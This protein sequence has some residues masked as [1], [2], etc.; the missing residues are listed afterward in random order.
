MP[1]ALMMDSPSSGSKGSTR[2]L[3]S[4]W[5]PAGARLLHK[6]LPQGCAMRVPQQAAE[7]FFPPPL[8]CE[9]NP[10]FGLF[11]SLSQEPNVG[12]MP[13]SHHGAQG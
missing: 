3:S 9:T 13:L 8:S 4:H 11:P 5:K 10:W 12:A 2:P 7:T 6:G 1:Q